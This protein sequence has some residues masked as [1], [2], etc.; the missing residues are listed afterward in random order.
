M[1]K[2]AKEKDAGSTMVIVLS[3][4]LALGAAGGVYY[5]YDEAVKAE[6]ALERS[7]EEYR[8]MA[9]W[10]KPVEDYLRKNKGKAAAPESTVDMLVFLDQKARE[11]QIGSGSIT[12]SKTPPTNLAS[13]QE[14]VYTATLTGKDPVKK[15]PIVDFLRKVEA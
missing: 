6:A 14:T 10:K 9:G 12:F 1:A 15:H 13:W 4:V 2:D 7:K 5:C 8:K 3:A 11:S